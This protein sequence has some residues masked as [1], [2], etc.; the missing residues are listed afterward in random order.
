MIFIEI[1]VYIMFTREYN[2]A[3]DEDESDDD[4]DRNAWDGVTLNLITRLC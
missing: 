1:N 4:D 2:V 3:T